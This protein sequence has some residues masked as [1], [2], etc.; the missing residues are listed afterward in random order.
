MPGE[1]PQRRTEERGAGRSWL[2]LGFLLAVGQLLIVGLLVVRA[3]TGS[4]LTPSVGHLSGSALDAHRALSTTLAPPGTSVPG[5]ASVPAQVPSAVAVPTTTIRAPRSGTAPPVAHPPAAPLHAI[6]PPAV[7][8]ANIAPQPNFLQSCSGAHYDDSVS[9]VAATV[10]AITHGRGAEGL[11]ALTL[12]SNWGQLTPSQQTFVSTNLERTVRGLPPLTAM[13]SVLD[14]AALQGADAG[15]DPSPPPS[16]PASQWGSNWA[17]AIGNPLEAL[18]FWMYDDGVSSANI[19]CTAA[20]HSGCW[21]HR[22]NVLMKLPCHEC[23]MG[24]G[25]SAGG[26]KGAPSLAELLVETSPPPDTEF[27]WQQE[28]PF[29]F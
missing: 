23:V 14:Q 12:P 25:W 28:T 27:T 16:F 9:C 15:I 18:Y 10:Q 29:L 13:A 20:D 19:D 17:G 22:Q 26:F 4:S 24:T 6:T 2:R 21:G 11:A 5:S 8:P 1:R 7:P 3:D